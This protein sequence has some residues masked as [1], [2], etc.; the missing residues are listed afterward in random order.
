[1]NNI[2]YPHEHV[3]IDLTQQKHNPD[4]YLNAKLHAVDEYRELK[5]HGVNRIVDCSNYGIGKNEEVVQYIEETVGIEIIRSTGFYKDPF[6]PEWFTEKPV[7][8]IAAVMID[9][10]QNNGCKVIGEIGTSLNQMTVNE[11]KLFEAACIAQKATN[12]VIITHT[13][14]GTYQK[15]QADFFKKRGIDLSKVIISHVALSKN[16][17]WIRSVLESGANVAFDTIGKGDYFDDDTQAKWIKQLI[18]SGYR[19]HLLIS[20]DITRQS[21]LK[22]NNGIG[23]CYLMDV[24]V[25]KLLDKQVSYRDIEHIMTE[26][27]DRI[28]K[29]V[30][31]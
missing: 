26:N 29:G 17:E 14:L 5:Q 8:E 21:H 19:D 10:I 22:K 1:M 16:I 2:T 6:F 12:A 20:M 25:A 15:E 11:E 13:T 4:C 7:S 30:M 31:Q 28:L 18:D 3:V 27:F 23:Y 24:F 9:D